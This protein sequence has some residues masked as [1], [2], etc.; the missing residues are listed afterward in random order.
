MSFDYFKSLYTF[1]HIINNHLLLTIK[2]QNQM[3]TQMQN[4]N[5]AKVRGGARPNAGRKPSGNRKVQVSIYVEQKSI[6]ALG[7]MSAVKEMILG[8]IAKSVK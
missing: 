6:E 3:E 8:V 2:N 4:Q 5:Q 7:G 1:A